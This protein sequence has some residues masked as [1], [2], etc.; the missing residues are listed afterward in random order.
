[1]FDSSPSPSP[2][3]PA[4]ASDGS[5]VVESVEP[6]PSSVGQLPADVGF[7]DVY[8]DVDCES[9]GWLTMLS[10]GD[11]SAV[12]LIDASSESRATDMLRASRAGDGRGAAVACLKIRVER[13][14]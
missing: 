12:P 13:V 5:A 3:R 9:G 6:V 2:V 4:P 11:L 1:M 14:D 7:V 8:G 10:G